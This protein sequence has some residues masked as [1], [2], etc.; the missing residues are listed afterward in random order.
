MAKRALCEV[1]FVKIGQVFFV[2][3]FIEKQARK[4]P[5]RYIS[6]AC[7]SALSDA[8]AH[9]VSPS[10]Q[11]NDVSFWSIM[12]FDC[13]CFDR[14]PKLS[15]QTANSTWYDKGHWSAYISYHAVSLQTLRLVTKD[16]GE[17]L[18]SVEQLLGNMINFW[19]ETHPDSISHLCHWTETSQIANI[20]LMAVQWKWHR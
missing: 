8:P 10:N 6:S 18:L 20:L 19:R 17:C 4:I 12:G 5:S 15:W 13:Q 2:W 16:L 9:R 1:H 7:R 14:E 11:L 3:N